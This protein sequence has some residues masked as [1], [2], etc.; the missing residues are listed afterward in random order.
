MIPN[1]IVERV[2][3]FLLGGEVT[4]GVLLV[5]IEG[6]TSGDCFFFSAVRTAERAAMAAALW[7]P[8]ELDLAGFGAEVLVSADGLN[9]AAKAAKA[10]ALC[11]APLRF[12]G[13][14]S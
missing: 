3:V 6:D 14:R 10:A 8:P 13:E 4:A 1:K 2:Q 9:E 11:V 5:D 7:D 12:A